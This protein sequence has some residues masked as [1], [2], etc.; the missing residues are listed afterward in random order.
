M[1]KN[2]SKYREQS[3]NGS[4]EMLSA[5]SI[6]DTGR[7]PEKLR[8]DFP[9]MDSVV[10]KY[11]FLINPYFL[12]LVLKHGEPLAKQVIPDTAELNDATG[13][14]DP[15]AE[16]R[17]SPVPNVTHRYPD[18]VLFLVS[19][20]CAM[21][22]RFCTRKRKIG[23]FA[24]ITDK[25]IEDGVKYIR[26]NSQIR[27]V[28]ISGGDP[29]MLSDAKLEW[30]LQLIR[31]IPHVEII[32]IGTRIPSALPQRITSALCRRLRS[33]QP[34]YI[35]VHF[36]HPLEITEESGKACRMLSDAG[37]PL[38]CQTVLLKGIND[39]TEVIESLMRRLLQIRVKPYYLLL[40]DL[41]RGTR[42]FR[43]CIDTGIQIMKYLRG[44]VSGMAVPTFIID[45]PGGGGKVPLLPEYMDKKNKNT[46]VFRNYQGKKFEY[47]E[48][49]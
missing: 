29:L 43:T 32:R 49:S 5:Q 48:K 28:L 31:D 17:D 41:V 14:E 7:L 37:I 26:G 19:G 20:I 9:G 3:D 23:R 33:F 1:G 4:W 46:Y 34:L 27:D 45:L 10:Q 35:N 25:T 18:R 8:S 24:P 11:P 15:L 47:Y 2:T 39:S 30:I 12:K 16:E 13:L 38:H 6:K 22:C 42:H 44:N 21:Y 40:P 36:N